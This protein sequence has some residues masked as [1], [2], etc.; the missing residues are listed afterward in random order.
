MGKKG[1]NRRSPPDTNYEYET[2]TTEAIRWVQKA[3]ADGLAFLVLRKVEQL[4]LLE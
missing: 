1:E 3:Y 4:G 2:K